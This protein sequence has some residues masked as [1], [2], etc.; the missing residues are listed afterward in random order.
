MHLLPRLFALLVCLGLAG[1]LRAEQPLPSFTF[2]ALP[3]LPRAVHHAFA[4]EH[5]GTLLIAG[6]MYVDEHGVETPSREVYALRPR[7]EAWQQVGQMPVALS[8]GGSASYGGGLICIGG[9]TADGP[10]TSVYVLSL[11]GDT[12]HTRR[13]PDLPQAAAE[14]G[15]TLWE[16]RLLVA[17]GRLADGQLSGQFLQLALGDPAATWQTLPAWPGEARASPVLVGLQDAAY[18]VGGETARGLAT[19][20]Y[21]YTHRL[22]WRAVTSP[23]F[24]ST[25]AAGA[26]FGQAHIFFF[27][28]RDSTGDASALILAYHSITDRWIQLDGWQR[29]GSAAH[30]ASLCAWE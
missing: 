19:E 21:R 4:G 12:L 16:G 3:D 1:L 24:W 11:V 22:G 30:I 29:D 15:A 14:V 13:L 6:G 20:G 8:H 25:G 7:A 5:G 26:S 17:G 10:V 9:H 28:G 27:G 18:L 23:P 2:P